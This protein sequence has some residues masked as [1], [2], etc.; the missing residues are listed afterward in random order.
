MQ[1]VAVA[2]CAVGCSSFCCMVK[3]CKNDN[4]TAVLRPLYRSTCVSRYLQLRTGGFRWCIVLLPA[5][6]SD[7][8]QCI[9]IREKTLEFSSTVLSTLSPYLKSCAKKSCTI[10]GVASA[11][12]SLKLFWCPMYKISYE[13]LTIILRQSYDRLT[14]DV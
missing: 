3:L 4:T 6:P 1:S 11:K 12:T 14:T 8:N 9:R 2:M 7:G 10:A 13:N 5:C